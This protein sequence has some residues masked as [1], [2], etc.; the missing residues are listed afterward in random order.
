M[1]VSNLQGLEGL[2]SLIDQHHVLLRKERKLP[3]SARSG[4][5]R[6]VGRVSFTSSCAGGCFFR[7]PPEDAPQE[8]LAHPGD[9]GGLLHVAKVPCQTVEMLS[10]SEGYGSIDATQGSCDNLFSVFR[11]VH[12]REL[13]KQVGLFLTSIQ[14]PPRLLFRVIANLAGA[15]AERA[16]EM[17][18]LRVFQIH[19]YSGGVIFGDNGFHTPRGNKIQ[20]P[21]IKLSSFH[22]S[23]LET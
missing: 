14:M 19:A 16:G 10:K 3:A 4:G 18:S 12:H 20:Q 22:G 9:H 21:L 23:F 5:F 2:K 1:A 6:G 13:R 7:R 11:A 15:S 8:T 17:L